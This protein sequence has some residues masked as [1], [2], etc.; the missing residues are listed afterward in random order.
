MPYEAAK[1]HYKMGRRVTFLLLGC[2]LAAALPAS[3]QSLTISG[4]SSDTGAPSKDFATE[5]MGDPWDFEELTDYNYNFST[6]NG[7]ANPVFQPMPTNDNGVLHGV[8]TS[9]QPKMAIHFEGIPGAFNLASKTGFKYP[10]DANRFKRLSFRLRRSAG[11]PDAH[12][13]IGAQWSTPIGVAGGGQKLL[14]IADV[15]SNQRINRGVIGS[16]QDAN[17][18][19]YYLDLDNCSAPCFGSWSGVMGGLYLNPVRNDGLAGSSI[20]LDWVRLTERGTAT[21]TLA[22]SGFGGRV[23][24][25]ATNAQTGDAIQ[26]FSDTGA[27]DFNN[28]GSYVWDYGF[29]PA[30]TWTI[31]AQAGA[32]SRT[33]TLN[34]DAMPVIN[35]TEPDATGGQDF[36]TVALADPWDLTNPQDLR[37]GGLNEIVSPNFTE[38]GLEAFSAPGG[39]PNPFVQF[40]G[41]DPNFRIDANTYHHFTFTLQN[42]HPELGSDI[43]SNTWGGICRVIWNGGSGGVFRQTQDLVVYNGIANTYTLDLAQL[44]DTNT[45]IE[46][47]GGQ[48]GPAWAGIMG[49]LWIRVNEAAVSRWFRLSNVKLTADDAPNGNGFFIVKWR[50]FDATGSREIPSAN[51]SDAVVNLYADTDTDPSSGLTLVQTNVPAANG[52]APIDVTGLAPGRYYIYAVIQDGSGNVQGRYST[53]PINVPGFPAGM[54]TDSNGNGLP[55]QWEAHYGV[56]NP[57]GD[58]D[59]DGVTNIQEYLRGTNPLVS[60]TMTLSEGATNS[61][62]TTRIALANPDSSPAEATLT[63]LRGPGSTPITRQYSLAPWGRATVKVND[64]AGLGGP[65]DVSTVIQSTTGGVIA[66]RTMFW[67]ST[68]Y[69]GSTG[70][71]I[72]QARRQWFLAEGVANNVFDTFILMANA[73]GSAANV[74]LHFLRD[75]AGPVD[76]VFQVPATSRVTIH[77]NDYPELNG[78]SFSTQA[79]SDQTITMER[80]TYFHWPGGR[81]FEGGTEDAAIPSL[82]TQ[83]YLAEGQTSPTF[84]E[85]ILLGNPNGTPAHVTLRYLMPGGRTATQNITVGASQ[86]LTIALGDS[87]PTPADSPWNLGVRN[88]DVSVAINS[89]VA[90]AVERAM[91][92][93]LNGGFWTDGHSSSGVTSQGTV[94]ALAE[95]EAGGPLGFESFILFANPNASTARVRLTFL[96]AG[97][98]APVTEDFDVPA[99]SRVT[100]YVG[101]FIARGLIAPGE[102]VGARIDSLNGVPLVIERAMYWNGGGETW[103]GGTGETGFKLK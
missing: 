7:T 16:Q 29:L 2:V 83:W 56:T 17:F 26:I 3:A 85:F 75:G 88:T 100:R 51:G 94:W 91:Y 1:G 42:D 5:V 49:N 92:W 34:I 37:F 59:G 102:Q 69:G 28:S 4:K 73:N 72:D 40:S 80:S 41:R 78:F 58:D 97:G 25:T 76:K 65:A 101:E 23:T 35:V 10:I 67:D 74:T 12:E 31:K 82:S 71:A 96:R 14:Y 89:D 103:G 18:H 36:A 55:D 39:N 53:G 44:D 57:N 43:L 46:D 6:I 64:I 63:F 62:F 21:K 8:L 48:P 68:Y 33:V 52:Q 61:F 99:N 50:T 45:E 95:G 19:I 79:T 93:N 24:L 47:Q 98:A 30:G 11:A 32:Q 15:I 70:K 22:W 38:F 54:R 86:R 9:G 90:I 27:V 20:D 66:E 60:N 84:A 81:A 77:T 13:F 87:S